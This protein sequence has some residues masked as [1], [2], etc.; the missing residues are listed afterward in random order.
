MIQTTVGSYIEYDVTEQEFL[1]GRSPQ[2]RNYQLK[3]RIEEQYKDISG[4]ISFRIARFRRGDDKQSWLPDSTIVIKVSSNKIIR[5]EAGR[6][7]VKIQF[8]LL[9]KATWNGNLYN[10]IGE[11]KYE[12]KNVGAVYKIGNQT[13]PYTVT[14]LQQN[15][16]TLVNQDKKIEIYAKEVGLIYKEKSVLQYCSSSAACVGKFQIDYGIKQVVRFRKLGK[17]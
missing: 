4:Q 16:S 5:N 3:E 14:V 7:F 12:L 1:V 17:E 10:N 6:D 15:D 8:P 11:D 2:I 13:F 9:E